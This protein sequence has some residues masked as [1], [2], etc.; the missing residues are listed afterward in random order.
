MT[1]VSAGTKSPSAGSTPRP[2]KAAPP[3]QSWAKVQSLPRGWGTIRNV[4]TVNRSRAAPATIS[5]SRS[6]VSANSHAGI[7]PDT[8]SDAS[9]AVIRS[10]SASGSRMAPTAVTP[11]NRLARKPSS[12]SETAAAAKT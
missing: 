3:R 9:S 8:A 10:L 11:V 1:W 7:A 5:T 12:A 2:A 6:S 4:G